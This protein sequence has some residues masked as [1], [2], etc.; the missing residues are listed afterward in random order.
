MNSLLETLAE[1]INQSCSKYDNYCESNYIDTY[2]QA[3][4]ELAEHGYFDIT[5]SDGP[6]VRG[7]VKWH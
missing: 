1:V 5:H 4:R 3:M 2:A 7:F 6:D